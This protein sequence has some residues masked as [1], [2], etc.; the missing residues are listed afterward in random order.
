MSGRIRPESTPRV[1]PLKR[2]A[3]LL[4][5]QLVAGPRSPCKSP[6]GFRISVVLH[7]RSFISICIVIPSACN[8]EL[9]GCLLWRLTHESGAQAEP[10]WTTKSSCVW[11]LGRDSIPSGRQERKI[12]ALRDPPATCS[13]FPSHGHPESRYPTA[14]TV[15]TSYRTRAWRD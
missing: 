15:L 10:I 1:T 3:N 12:P 2:T 7:V 9:S 14:I 5:H 6:P 13:V 4:S 8:D 11:I